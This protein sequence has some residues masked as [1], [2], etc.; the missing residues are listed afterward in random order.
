MMSKPPRILVIQADA[1]TRDL[2]C[3]MLTLEN[4]EAS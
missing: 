1:D 3:F 2:L 4:Y